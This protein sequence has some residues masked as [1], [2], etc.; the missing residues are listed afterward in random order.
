ME[1]PQ[2]VTPLP[3]VPKVEGTQA[4]KPT[5]T[6]PPTGGTKTPTTSKGTATAAPAGAKKN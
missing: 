1:V 6:T 4:P 3:E 5:T 2:Q